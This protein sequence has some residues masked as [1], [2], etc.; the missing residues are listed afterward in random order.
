MHL[1]DEFL[2]GNYGMKDQVM[3]LRWVQKYIYLFGGNKEKVTL[4]GSSA[5]AV[6]V[7]WHMYSPQSSGNFLI[8][9]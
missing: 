8:K 1:D 9:K 4:A 3:V 5:G 2:S 7:N 6:S